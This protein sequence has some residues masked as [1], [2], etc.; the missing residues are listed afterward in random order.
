MIYQNSVT[1]AIY[2]ILSNNTAV[3]AAGAHI[4]LNGLFNQDPNF[5]PWVGIYSAPVTVE[6]ERVQRP[7]PWKILYTPTLYIQETNRSFNGEN[8]VEGLEDFLNTVITAIDTHSNINRRLNDTVD[9][10]TGIQINPYQLDIEQSDT[11]FSYEVIINAERRAT[12]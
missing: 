5:S 9:M 11:I 3:Q 4:V 2:D 1:S 7:N 6:P 10:I 8:T 12:P